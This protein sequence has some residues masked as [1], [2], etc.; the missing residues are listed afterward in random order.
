MVP[1]N[2]SSSSSTVRTKKWGMV[3]WGNYRHW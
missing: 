2:S 3:Q 1:R